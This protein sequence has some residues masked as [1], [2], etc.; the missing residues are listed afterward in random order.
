MVQVYLGRKSTKIA[1]EQILN[2]QLCKNL[3]SFHRTALLFPWD[4]SFQFSASLLDVRLHMCTPVHGNDSKDNIY[5]T[6]ALFSHL[7]TV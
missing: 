1:A 3:I 2:G 5:V 7:S 4:Y 6:T